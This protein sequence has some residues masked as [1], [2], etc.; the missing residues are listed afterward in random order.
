MHD[1]DVQ[2]LLIC[3]PA[4]VV[5]LTLFLNARRFTRLITWRQRLYGHEG[6]E[7]SSL[8]YW[9]FRIAF[10][11]FALATTTFAILAVVRLSLT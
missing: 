5:T 4:A 6:Y 8:I 7:A 10:G 1:D 3:L 2:I 11:L 9:Y